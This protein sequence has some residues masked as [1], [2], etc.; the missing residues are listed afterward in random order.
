[1]TGKGEGDRAGRRDVL[2][3]TKALAVP[4]SGGRQTGMTM[5][6]GF[7][8]RLQYVI[9]QLGGPVRAARHVD[10]HY[11][12]LARWRD[13]VQKMPFQAAVALC[14][15][16]DVSIA[17]LAAGDGARDLDR[18]PEGD[19]RPETAKLS[20]EA[21]HEAANFI[22]RAVTAFKGLTPEQVADAVVSRARDHDRLA[23]RESHAEDVESV[24]NLR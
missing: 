4:A 18:D 22:F 21:V 12:T 6:P 8:E 14:E 17:W 7:T 23:E 19:G 24:S 2:G 1:M 15:A 16:A 20:E 5:D 10:A 11:D 13:G 3:E 9:E